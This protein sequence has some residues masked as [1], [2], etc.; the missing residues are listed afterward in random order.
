M[1]VAGWFHWISEPPPP[2]ASWDTDRSFSWGKIQAIHSQLHWRFGR[3]QTRLSTEGLFHQLRNQLIN[4]NPPM[5]THVWPSPFSLY[6]ASYKTCT[7]LLSLKTAM[8]KW[9][10]QSI[11]KHQ[12]LL[13]PTFLQ[14]KKALVL[15]FLSF[16]LCFC[17]WQT[18][19]QS[20]LS[21]CCQVEPLSQSRSHLTPCE[22]SPF[23]YLFTCE[24]FEVGGLDDSSS[25]PKS[26][27]TG[28]RHAYF[29]S[30]IITA[31]ASLAG[32]PRE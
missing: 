5:D 16:L 11:K 28:P 14:T 20:S 25:N 1:L 6:Y 3:G 13:W 17:R 27:Y 30:T 31:E 22:L 9:G 21:L 4:S 10:K 18:A 12:V 29:P 8:G 2:P 19:S 26:N 23:H 24:L 32:E 7:L 15:L